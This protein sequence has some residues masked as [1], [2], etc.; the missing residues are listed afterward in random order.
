MKLLN[1]YIKNITTPEDFT[2]VS[3]GA[4][5]GIFVDELFQSN[6]I[7]ERWNAYFIEPVKKRFDLLVENYNMYFTNNNFVYLN[8][9]ISN[10]NEDRTLI[11]YD[12]D[13]SFGLCSF[14]REK[15]EKTVTINVK[16]KTFSDFICENNISKIDL[17][18]IDTEGMDY[19]IIL[20]C[21]EAKIFPKVILFEHIS[22]QT[23]GTVRTYNDVIDAID[24]YGYSM[25]QDEAEAQ[26]EQDNKLLIKKEHNGFSICGHKF[27]DIGFYINLDW[28][29][30]RKKSIKK[31]INKFNIVGMERFP[32]L[33]DKITDYSCTKS[34]LG[35]YEKAINDNHDIIFV[36]ED[37]MDIRD[38]SYMQDNNIRTEDM[39]SILHKELYE[40]EWDVVLLGCNPSTPTLPVSE[41]LT[42][43]GNSTGAWAYLIKKEACEFIL[44]NSN[45]EIDYLAV[46]NWL[47]KLNR[48][49]FK[50]LAS[51]HLIIHHAEGFISTL[52]PSSPV[53]YDN[54]IK[55]NYDAHM[56]IK[57][58]KPEGIKN[59][60]T[61]VITGHFCDNYLNH[62]RFLLHSLDD[63]LRQCEFLVIYD[64][65]DSTNIHEDRQKLLDYFKYN[66]KDLNVGVH[67]GF[68]GLINSVGV[69]LN[70]VSTDF[71]LFLEHDWVFI[72]KIDFDA[73]LNALKTH[74]HINAIWF[75]KDDNV[76]RGFD[77][78]EDKTGNV[79][80]FCVDQDIQEV[81]L[82]KTCRW[83]NNPALF[84]V[85]KYNN[86]YNEIIYNEHVGIQNQKAFNVEQ[87]MIAYFRNEVKC[88]IWDDV[89]YR[90]GT[91]LYGGVGT[92]PYVGH[93]DASKRYN[94][95]PEEN[96]EKYMMDNPLKAPLWG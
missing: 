64:N 51:K 28:C 86:W 1:E 3:I 87:P 66:E 36:C 69:A 37:D 39:L 43:I 8:Y 95:A 27:A 73:C 21:F 84:R 90:F 11:T 15:N 29:E 65:G 6:L 74:D 85:N 68:G 94:T 92:G 58:K 44:R 45:Y 34:H 81:Q 67:F 56:N 2:V 62:L 24:M 52:N 13:D 5:D 88:G 20:Q 72:D 18:K 63:D 78:C 83:S 80:E 71:M 57:N 40:V 42:R 50:T 55:G 26:Y 41:N 32:A 14:F 17:L 60:I 12:N 19:E 48:H 35:V 75:S 91:Y 53:Y 59:N 77:I 30:D 25:V 89:F 79:H 23:D 38:F 93:T 54:W 46:D 9:A 22:L 76:M 70:A 7:D 10:S 47:P 33:T 96:G 16:C 82:I 31:Q 61:I 4:N 49:G